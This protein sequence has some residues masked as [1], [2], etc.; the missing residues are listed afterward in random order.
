VVWAEYGKKAMKR[1]TSGKKFYT[2]PG[3]PSGNRVFPCEYSHFSVLPGC[4]S[5]GFI[6]M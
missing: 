4:K 6:G 5:S 2:A 1:C 3:Y